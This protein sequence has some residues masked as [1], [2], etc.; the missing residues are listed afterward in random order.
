MVAEAH[1]S[2]E[3]VFKK[4]NSGL[5]AEVKYDGERLQLHKAGD[6][7]TYFSR[8]LKQVPAHKTEHLREYVKKAIPLAES[9]I[10]DGEILLYDTV[11][12]CPLPFGTLG[13]H[14]KKNFKE[15]TVCFMIFD[16]VYFNGTCLL[17][18]PLQERRK[19]MQENIQTIPGRIMLT[20]QKLVT[21][22]AELE[23]LFMES[24][25]DNLEGL[26]LKD[27]EGAYE[28]GK[29]H[30]IKMKKDYINGG[31]LADSAD[32]V[33]LGAYYGTGLFG[34]VKSIYL[35]GCMN[36]KTKKWY[37]VTKVGNG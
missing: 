23:D 12:N 21:N 20:D 13:V 16:C 11:K 28:P 15:A 8:S 34:G 6:N 18:K 9:I 25:R 19:I 30:W 14:K 26:V 32:L 4:C 33:V 36:P 37:T 24:V 10:L 35:M 27:P 31:G 17:N 29:R 3:Q 5:Y 7:F 1:S 22:V 2:F